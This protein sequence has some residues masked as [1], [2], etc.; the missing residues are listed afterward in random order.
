MPPADRAARWWTAYHREL[1]RSK[2]PGYVPAP[3]L[4][5]EEYEFIPAELHNQPLADTAPVAAAASAASVAA[6]DACVAGNRRRPDLRGSPPS[7]W[8]SVAGQRPDSLSHR[9]SP[10]HP[11]PGFLSF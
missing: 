2:Q 11:C 5:G 4:D 6:N 8:D 9:K 1:E 7:D 3:R 10:V